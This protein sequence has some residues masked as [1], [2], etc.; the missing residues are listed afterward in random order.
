VN[1]AFSKD[2]LKDQAT[3]SLNVSDLFNSRKRISET[4]L[5]TLNSYSEQQWRQRQINLSFTYRF[6]K[7]KSDKEKDKK[8]RG[9]QDNQDG[10]DFPG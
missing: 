3:V 8:P 10:G 7:T 6:N 4:N 2:V 1:L 5:A 9:N